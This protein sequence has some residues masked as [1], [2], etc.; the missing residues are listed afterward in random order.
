MISFESYDDDMLFDEL[1]DNISGDIIHS[2][3]IAAKYAVIASPVD[4]GLF[5][6][7]WNASVN[8]E[9]DGQF[10]NEDP[11]G[12]STIGKMLS[13]IESFDL[14]IDKKIF[15]QNNVRNL[16]DGSMYASTVSWDY[17]TKTADSIVSG[18]AISALESLN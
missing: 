16:D 10:I 3:S 13:D 17:S 6:G 14:K 8:E 12:T 2:A 7:N 18:A 11:S 1:M 4:T 9:Y 15:I 5:K